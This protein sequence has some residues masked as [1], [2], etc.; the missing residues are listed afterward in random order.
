MKSRAHGTQDDSYR[1]VQPVRFTRVAAVRVGGAAVRPLQEP[2]VE[3]ARPQPTAH[4]G[5]DERP[6]WLDRVFDKSPFLQL[7]EPPILDIGSG[8][9]H[10]KAQFS[11]QTYVRLDLNPAD[12]PDIVGDGMA[13]PFRTASFGG[14]IC[15]DVL[16]HVPE[17]GRLLEEIRR[18][19]RPGGRL[20]VSVPF[21]YPYHLHPGDY[22]RF[23]EMGM[24]Y[25]LRAAGFRVLRM[26]TFSTGLFSC[27][28]RWGVAWTY[29]KPAWL[30]WF[31][32]PAARACVHLFNRVDVAKDRF[33]VS[34]FCTAVADG[35]APR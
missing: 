32:Q 12:V 4:Y 8:V 16:E 15:A 31:L 5:A 30:Q 1:G 22:Y 33:G 3:V 28:T 17:P 18:V 11:G 13:L 26:T 35:A 2:A 29:G 19:L 21:M 10:F 6:A 7:L 23:T 27:V 20:F 25:V 24:E 9:R 14:V 34:I